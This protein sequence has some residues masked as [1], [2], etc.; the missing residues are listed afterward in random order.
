MENKL[1]V[2]GV[3]SGELSRLFE[4]RFNHI[5]G[6]VLTFVEGTI[7]DPEQR[8]AAKD[9][10]RQTMYDFSRDWRV[11]MDWICD[12]LAEK[13]GEKLSPRCGLSRG[14]LFDK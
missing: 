14:K 10:M 12:E 3:V 4:Y 6:R 9:I 13:L 5:L 11:D 2:S 1:L 8:K 7:S